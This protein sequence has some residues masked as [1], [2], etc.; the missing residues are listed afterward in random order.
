MVL[1]WCIR[2]AALA[3]LKRHGDRAICSNKSANRPFQTATLF[4][5]E[6]QFQN[7]EEIAEDLRNAASAEGM[8][9]MKKRVANGEKM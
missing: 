9:S 2:I 4:L 7:P 1:S 3:M 6:V 8:A 5:E